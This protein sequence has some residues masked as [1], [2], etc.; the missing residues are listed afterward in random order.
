MI[1]NFKMGYISKT[2]LDKIKNWKYVG[3][4]YSHLDNALNPFWLWCA[5]FVPEKVSPN[6]V[7]LSGLFCPA[8]AAILIV[9]YNG[10]LTEKPPVWI[11]AFGGLSVWLFQ[12]L[13]AIDGKHARNTRQSSPLG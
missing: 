1:D 11:T 7:S 9:I 8:I 6:M 2:G 13:D 12:T 4:P 5:D 3:G 10:S